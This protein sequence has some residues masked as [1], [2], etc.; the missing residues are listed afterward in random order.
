MKKIITYTGLLVLAV[1]VLASCE[2]DENKI[3]YEGGTAPALSANKTG[4]IPLSF[5]NKDNEAITFNWTNPNYSF[6]TGLSSQDVNYILEIDSLGGNFSS[7]GKISISVGKDL[8]KTLTQSELNDLL[9]NQ[10]V[11]TPGRIYN[12]QAR[13]KSNIA[14]SASTQLIS[15][16]LSFTVTPYAIPPKVNPPT[17]G[18]L[19]ITGSA[20]PAS[21]QCGCGEPELLSQKFNR[22][23]STLYELSSINLTAG[24]SY[25][26]LPVYGSWSAKYG[27]TGAGN[28]NNPISDDFKDGGNDIKA[29]DV[30]G[31]YKITVDFQRGKF[32]LTKL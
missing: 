15:N 31:A 19:Y 11:L 1:L 2:K 23:S 22:I 24:G 25:L 5:L 29:P 13:I 12:L 10:M 17:S 6:T 8:T 21:W 14:S 32:T 18:T 30:G 7:A 3:Y 28:T 9:L 26:F 27:F 16:V 4:S 20:T